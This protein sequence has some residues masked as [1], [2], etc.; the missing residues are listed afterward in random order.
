MNAL[1]LAAGRGSRLGSIGDA[2]PKCLVELAGRALLDWQIDALHAAGIGRVA[3][4]DGY[5]ADRIVRPGLRRYSNGRWA[6]TGIVASLACAGEWLSDGPTIV[7]YADI[8][9]HPRI[10]AALIDAPGEVVVAGD[11]DWRALWSARFIDPLVDAEA[12]RF[13]GDRLLAIGGPAGAI[14]EIEAQYLGLV[15]WAPGGARLLERTLAACPAHLAERIDM[16]AMLSRMLA[17][18]E[19]IRFA[20]VR[21]HWCEVDSAADLQLY[22]RLAAVPGWHHDWRT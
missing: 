20:P 21:G 9:Y 1:I 12:F 10:V 19:D 5:L 13:R 17:A 7:A 16:T 4:V 3:I 6:S 22:Q 2:R 8:V 15:K 11:L 18:G 14:D